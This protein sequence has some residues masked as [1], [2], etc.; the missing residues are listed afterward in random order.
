MN[1]NKTRMQV[2]AALFAAVCAVCSQLTIP[3]QPVPITLGTFGVLMA[4]GFLGKRYG[5]LSLVIYLLL[6]A[7]GV[8]VFSM[9]RGGIS[10]LAGP[11][12]GFIIGFA[13]MAFVTGL[14][15]EKLGYTFSKMIA[16]TFAGTV[17]CYAL[18]VGWFMYLTGNGIAS[19]FALCVAPFL[20]GDGAKILLSSFLV[21]RY[22]KRLIGDM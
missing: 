18:G 8:P 16:A 5:F 21:S 11:A 3:I 10:V 1:R 13:P 6:G 20:I 9:M 15:A 7:A 22:R 12:G 4:G 17:A 19:A 2:L 14:F